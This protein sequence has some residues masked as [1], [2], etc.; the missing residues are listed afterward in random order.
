LYPVGVAIGDVDGD[1][2]PDIVVTN[3]QDNPNTVS[4]FKNTS[5]SGSITASS[6]ASKVD[7]TTGILAIWRSHIVMSME[8]VNQ[9]S[10]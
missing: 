2:K 4:V 9:T 7:F 8:M 3:Q 1:G 5:T 6:F 10:L